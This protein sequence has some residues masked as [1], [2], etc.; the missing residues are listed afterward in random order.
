MLPVGFEP[1]ISVGGR[2]QT[3]ALDR[4]AT[5]TGH[6]DIIYG[7]NKYFLRVYV[8][9]Y[10]YKIPQGKSGRDGLNRIWTGF[11]KFGWDKNLV[12]PA[13]KR[14]VPE[15]TNMRIFHLL[16]FVQQNL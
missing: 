11:R 5:G 13:P 7:K 9:I 8:Y 4:A 14:D 2:P 3:H 16:I 12:F 6:K 1:A 15:L 10:I